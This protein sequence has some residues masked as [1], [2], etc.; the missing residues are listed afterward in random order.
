VGEEKYDEWPPVERT[1]MSVSCQNSLGRRTLGL[2]P[3]DRHRFILRE[4]SH[5]LFSAFSAR[6]GRVRH[7]DIHPRLAGDSLVQ[8]AKFLQCS[9]FQSECGSL[10]LASTAGQY[11]FRLFKEYC[12]ADLSRLK[13]KKIGLRW[14]LHSEVI[15]GKGQFVC[16][17]IHCNS[18]DKLNSYE[19][20][21]SFHEADISKEALVKLRLC[22]ACANCL[23]EERIR[24]YIR[25]SFVKGKRRVLKGTEEDAITDFSGEVN[26]VLSSKKCRKN[27]SDGCEITDIDS[28]VCIRNSEHS[29]T[30]D[31]A[32]WRIDERAEYG[33]L[34]NTF[35]N[36]FNQMLNR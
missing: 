36:Y 21:F 12:I 2:R 29:S 7:V 1:E 22:S 31:D 23:L 32:S 20:P 18:R 4:F 17:N 9:S 13:K 11:Y 15:S 10:Q 6:Q 24:N 33:T 34:N 5:L 26:N 27:S 3:E 16:G 8:G 28:D 14:R 25:D 30:P 35:H 19:V